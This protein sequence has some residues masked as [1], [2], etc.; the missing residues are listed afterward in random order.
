MNVILIK[1]HC[2]IFSIL[3]FI[4]EGNK[5]DSIYS[6]GF[7]PEGNKYD[8]IYS[9]GFKFPWRRFSFFL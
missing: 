6:E 8:S 4:P 2:R 9:E 3:P 7:I 5:Y 1:K